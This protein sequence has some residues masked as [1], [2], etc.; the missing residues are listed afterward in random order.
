MD[1]RSGD[2]VLE[3]GP[4]DGI[5]TRCLLE[6]PADRIV[7]VELD[8]RCAEWI[9]RL[10]GGE[11]RFR[12]IEQDFLKV[13]L[14]MIA[15]EGGTIRVVGNIPYAITSPILFRLLDN[16]RHV[17]DFAVTVQKEVGR[18]VVSPPGSKAYGIPS[19]LFQLHAEVRELFDIPP[20]AFRPVP[21]VDST[22]L[23]GRFLERPG[24]EVRDEPFFRTFV[25]TLFGQRRKMIRNTVKKWS[26]NNEGWG[27]M[28]RFLEMRPEDLSVK[29]FAELSNH[30][31]TRILP[32]QGT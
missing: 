22:V 21:K 13:D 5:L 15:P 32:E 10:Y 29:D 1:V 20:G 11:N 30:V 18:R 3:I 9:R 26:L 7:A 6:S 23:Y 12:L 16:R 27:E 24:V 19:V 8:R 2:V 31:L 4:G 25:K 28:S 14:S 17:R